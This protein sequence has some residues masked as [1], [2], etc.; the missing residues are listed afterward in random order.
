M[1]LLLAEDE[2]ELS[3]AIAAILKHNNYS[4]DAVYDGKSAFDWGMTGNYD[5]ILLDLMMP[6]MN[7]LDVLVKLRSN[8]VDTPV[9]ILT[10]KSE[11]EDRIAGLDAGAD[12]YLPKPFA[13]GEL[14]ARVRA[15]TRRKTTFV[16][17][18][19]T[20]GTLSLNRQTYELSCG[21]ES[22]RLAGKEYQ[23]IEMLMSNPNRLI[24]IEQFMERVWGYDTET[25]SSVVWVYISNLRKKLAGLD[26]NVEIKATR[27][28]GYYLDVKEVSDNG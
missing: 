11:V 6:G 9:I 21:S 17:D 14:L 27:N 2:K 24:S 13:M 4:V 16:P 23:M 28:A 3:N 25:E 5:A 22:I 15:V 7:G 26:A 8:G 18:T 12:D 20:A 19:I 10:A 1:R